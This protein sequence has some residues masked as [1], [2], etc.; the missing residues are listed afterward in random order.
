MHDQQLGG[1]MYGPLVV[2]EPGQKFDPSTDKVLL[3]SVGGPD[4]DAARFLNGSDKPEPMQLRAGTKYRFRVINI[5]YNNSQLVLSLLSGS[6]PVNWKAI[7]KDGADLPTQQA[8]VQPARQSITVG[9]TRDFEFQPTE[10]G[11]LRFEV[12]NR[13]GEVR[14]LMRVQVR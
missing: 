13:A 10:P 5:T 11:E 8:V 9:E 2:V 7:A 6:S 12:T 3:I 14:I 1:G 4:D